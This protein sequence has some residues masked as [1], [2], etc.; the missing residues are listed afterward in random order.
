MLGN[1]ERAFNGR[2]EFTPPPRVVEAQQQHR[3]GR[4]N[5]P[6]HGRVRAVIVRL[7]HYLKLGI[8]LD[9]TECGHDSTDE[10][11]GEMH[12]LDDQYVSSPLSPQ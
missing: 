2:S 4:P 3:L 8:T 6:G 5:G 9:V 11:E 1:L 12:E 10:S 7:C